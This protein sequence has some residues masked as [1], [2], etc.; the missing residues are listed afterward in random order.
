MNGIKLLS[1]LIPYDVRVVIEEKWG[2]LR[3]WLVEIGFVG[4]VI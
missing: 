2:W 1:D 4:Q 3:K